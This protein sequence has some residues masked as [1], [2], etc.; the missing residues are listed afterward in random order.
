MGFQ[1]HQTLS[2]AFSLTVSDWYR[3]GHT[4]RKGRYQHPVR[5][6]PLA[7]NFGQLFGTTSVRIGNVVFVVCCIVLL[8]TTTYKPHTSS[9][10]YRLKWLFILM[11]GIRPSEPPRET[12]MHHPSVTPS[13]HLNDA[14]GAYEAALVV[15]RT[16]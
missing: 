8:H 7:P 15:L 5:V 2:L 12:L 9:A 10:D 3:L 14:P 16:D 13:R 11:Y 6:E 1:T 4:T